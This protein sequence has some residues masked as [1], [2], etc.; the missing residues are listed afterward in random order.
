MIQILKVKLLSGIHAREDWECTFEVPT[1]WDLVDL[2]LSIQKL[3][4][5]DN[6]HLFE[7]YIGNTELSHER[8]LF[9]CDEDSI[10]DTSIAEILEL[11]K[12]KK[13]LFYMFDY[14]DSWRFQISKSRKKPYAVDPNVEYPVMLTETGT[15]PEQY[16]GWD[17]DWDDD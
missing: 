14:G 7:F 13:K 2:H 15:K 3:V 17:D 9:M 1:D 11:M 8:Q 4:D 10:E 12:G 16:P 6:D 5:F